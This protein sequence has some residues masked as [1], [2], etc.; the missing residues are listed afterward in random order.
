ML[1]CAN[2]NQTIKKQKT[3]FKPVDRQAGADTGE[4]KREVD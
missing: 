1:H 3:K 4:S 2:Q